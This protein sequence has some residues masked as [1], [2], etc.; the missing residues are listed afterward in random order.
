VIALFILKHFPTL[1]LVRAIIF[2]STVPDNS[3][4]DA[5]MGSLLTLD[6]KI[7][8]LRT[9]AKILCGLS[10]CQRIFFPKARGTFFRFNERDCPGLAKG[11]TY[12]KAWAMLS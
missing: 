2:S 1:L 6:P 4:H 12:C 8:R 7:H 3:A 5:D 10:H 9:H 11:R